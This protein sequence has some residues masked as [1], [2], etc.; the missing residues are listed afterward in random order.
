MNVL[1]PAVRCN[2]F[3]KRND[4]IC[5]YLQKDAEKACAIYRLCVIF[6]YELQDKYKGYDIMSSLDY[7]MFKRVNGDIV[8][9]RN[10]KYTADSNGFEKPVVRKEWTTKER[11][12]LYSIV[13]NG[14]RN[15]FNE[16]NAKF[17]QAG[18]SN[19]RPVHIA[20][21]KRAISTNG[22]SKFI[23]NLPL[24]GAGN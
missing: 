14:N 23:N 7:T 1:I 6:I 13:E 11:R 4:E 15:T 21:V 17:K 12:C 18:Y 19:L 10:G 22:K 8:L 2:D 16:V 24:F 20:L 9:D 3:L 5:V